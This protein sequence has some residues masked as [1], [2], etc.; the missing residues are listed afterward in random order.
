MLMPSIFAE[1][2]FDEFFDDLPLPRS[3][4]Q[5]ERQLY[6]RHGSHEMSTDVHEHE[7]HYEMDIDLPGFKKDDIHLDLENGYLSITASKNLEKDTKGK[8]GKVIRQERYAGTMQ[9]SFYVGEAI[10]EKDVKARFEDGV[11]SLEI[12]KVEQRKLPEKRTIMIEG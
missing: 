5:M 11:L 7:D 2:L 3:Y 10:T 1:N 12:P 6:G 4:R 9:R 8:K